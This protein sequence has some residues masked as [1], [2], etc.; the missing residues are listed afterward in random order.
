[1]GQDPQAFVLGYHIQC[2]LCEYIAYRCII[3]DG[4][5]LV[6]KLRPLASTLAYNAEYGIEFVSRVSSAL[7]VS[8]LHQV[9]Q[10]IRLGE[11]V[12]GVGIKLP[13]GN[14]SANILVRAKDVPSHPTP[15]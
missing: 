3:V 8:E 6:G 14:Q 1:M 12:V 13:V 11:V 15:G 10:A 2:V 7:N 5:M 9:G 4:T